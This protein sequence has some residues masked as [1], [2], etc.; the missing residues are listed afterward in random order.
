MVFQPNK[1]DAFQSQKT[2]LNQPS[3]SKKRLLFEIVLSLITLV[4]I[5]L[6]AYLFLFSDSS[7]VWGDS[8]ESFI[9]DME[10]A[11]IDTFCPNMSSILKIDSSKTKYNS[12]TDEITLGVILLN[13]SSI[14]LADIN[15]LFYSG[16]SVFVENWGL[17]VP[18]ND[19]NKKTKLFSSKEGKYK[20]I[21]QITIAPIIWVGNT[22][23]QC[24]I[25][26]S[27]R[28]SPNICL[29]N[30]PLGCEEFKVR[31][32][33]IEIVII[34]GAMSQIKLE[35]VSIDNCGSIEG[36]YV[37]KGGTIDLTIPCNTGSEGQIFRGE[38]QVTFLMS[39]KT[40]SEK[41]SG[42]IVGEINN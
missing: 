24:D 33:G 29:F 22:R 8:K 12:L 28:I 10:N 3:L 11:R 26:D 5:G 41:V 27:R 9:E 31:S 34:N 16:K 30:S 4:I 13:K 21:D 7:F 38:S 39:G 14:E 40:V 1:E 17:D 36:G 42:S 2:K 19:E 6:V 23:E 32:T 20:D 18:N 25:S 37:E 35:N 15:L